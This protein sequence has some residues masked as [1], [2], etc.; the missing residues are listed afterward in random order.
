MDLKKY[1]F[2]TVG[3]DDSV[4]FTLKTDRTLLDEAKKRGYYNGDTPYNKLFS[5]VFFN[6]GQV[7]IKSG[8]VDEGFKNTAWVYLL[9]LMKSWEPKHEE[10]EAVCAMIMSELLEPN[11]V[12][13]KRGKK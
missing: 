11:L 13:S 10:K 8:L 2:Q 3:G 7:K 4:F 5:E 6:G 9:S 12:K 1:K